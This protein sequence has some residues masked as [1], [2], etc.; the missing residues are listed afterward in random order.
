MV[1]RFVA[2]GDNVAQA[3]CTKAGAALDWIPTAEQKLKN[4]RAHVAYA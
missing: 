3:A 1:C 2:S 4:C